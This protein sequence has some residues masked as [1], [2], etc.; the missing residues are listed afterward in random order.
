M[1]FNSRMVWSSSEP[2]SKTV[3]CRGGETSESAVIARKERI[4]P[5]AAAK[6][7]PITEASPGTTSERERHTSSAKLENQGNKDDWEACPY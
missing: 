3:G 1:G 6:R 7:S 4:I 5:C 2:A